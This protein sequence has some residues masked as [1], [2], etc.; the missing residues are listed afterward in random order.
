MRLCGRRTDADWVNDRAGYRCRHG[1]HSARTR[2]RGAPR[3]LYVREDELMNR[4]RTRLT[5]DQH[6]S[7]GD[8]HPD[9]SEQ[10]VAKLRAESQVI[11]CGR[12]DWTLTGT[13]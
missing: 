7:V 11:V 2:P 3:N 4:L 8:V 10:I 13:G 9:T 6:R 12:E 5:S 1:Y